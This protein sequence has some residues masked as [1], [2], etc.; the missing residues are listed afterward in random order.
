M[1]DMPQHAHHQDKHDAHRRLVERLRQQARD[2]HRLASG[3]EE[4]QI[5]QRTV[6]EKWSVKELVCHLRRV[7]NVFE[8]RMEAM[9]AEDNPALASYEP[10][11]DSEFDKLAAEPGERALAGFLE[12]RERFLARLEELTPAQWHRAGR[13]PAFPNY[14]VHFQ[15]EYLAHHEAH[16]IYQMFERRIP[17]GKMPH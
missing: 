4:Q 1:V 16:H 7:Q 11:G 10:E 8:E 2:V 5:A 9:L 14:D 13:H 6:P 3:L 12:D 17:L 15:T